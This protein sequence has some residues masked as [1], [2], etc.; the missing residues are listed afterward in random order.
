MAFAAPIGVCTVTGAAPFVMIG[1]FTFLAFATTVSSLDEHL[2]HRRA[3][4]LDIRLLVRLA[5]EIAELRQLEVKRAPKLRH[6]DPKGRSGRVGQNS[7]ALRIEA[8]HLSV[9]GEHG[10]IE[11]QCFLDVGRRMDGVHQADDAS[12]VCWIR[13]LSLR[14]HGGGEQGSQCK[15]GKSTHETRSLAIRADG[16]YH[17]GPALTLSRRRLGDGPR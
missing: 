9:E 2:H 11:R 6:R 7:R 1:A 12:L 15:G 3:G 5:L 13:R 14:Q 4:I 10:L 17:V 16:G 8:A